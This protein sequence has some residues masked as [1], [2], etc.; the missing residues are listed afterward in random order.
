MTEPTEP[1]LP[2]APDAE[3]PVDLRDVLLDLGVAAGR[4]RPRRRKTA[5]W[6]CSRWRRIVSL[7]EPRYDLAEVAALSGVDAR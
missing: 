6:S 2:T 3:D 5:R 7:D 1:P 4:H